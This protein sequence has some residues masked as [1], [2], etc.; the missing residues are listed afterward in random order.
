MREQ[1]YSPYGAKWKDG[2]EK[3]DRGKE[4]GE[5]KHMHAWQTSFTVLF[6]LG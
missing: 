2:E 1:R 6:H 3:V 4:D 5:R